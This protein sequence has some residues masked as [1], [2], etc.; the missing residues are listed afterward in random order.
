[1]KWSNKPFADALKDLIKVTNPLISGGVNL[2]EVARR[3][4]VD[5]GYLH[6]LLTGKKKNP[7]MEQ[8]EKIAKFFE[9]YHPGFSP[10]YFVEYRVV[11]INRILK[12]YPN[13]SKTVLEL[14]YDITKLISDLPKAS[15]H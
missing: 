10:E 1:M 12:D 13:L 5:V 2:N 3:S 4:G 15:G 7:G 8:I 9:H 11:M 14:L 6:R